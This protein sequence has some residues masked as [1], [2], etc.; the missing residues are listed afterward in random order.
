[1]APLVF[2]FKQTY[3]AASL[4]SA[5]KRFS[6]RVPS[7]HIKTSTAIG[8]TSGISNSSNHQPERSVSCRRRTLTAR[9]G[10]NTPR[11]YRAPSTGAVP[12]TPSTTLNTM[13]AIT[14]NNKNIQY[15]VRRARPLKV[16]YF[17]KTSIYQ[18]IS[19]HPFF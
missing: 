19:E 11:E 8:P 15:S 16:T 12:M 2:T 6:S 18:F 3:S 9:L 4:G 5:P 7:K 17:F 14:L 13:E 10:S 1:M